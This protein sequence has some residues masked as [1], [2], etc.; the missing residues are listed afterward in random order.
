[1]DPY[2]QVGIGELQMKPYHKIQSMF[3][4]DRNNH[5][6]IIEGDWAVREFSYLADLMWTFTEKVDGTNIR[7]TWDGSK[8]SLLGR[9]ENSQTPNALMQVLDEMFPAD[10]L[11]KQFGAEEQST[12]LYG[13]GYGGGIQKGGK[14]RGDMSFVLF[15]VRCGHW[16][17]RR[18]DVDIIASE[19]GIDSVPEIDAGTLHKGIKIV[20]Q[21][22]T[23]TW[24]DFEAEGIVARPLVQ[25]F[26]RRRQRIIAKIKTCDFR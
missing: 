6:K 2:G 14:Y 13:E 16:W 10:K 17:L 1:M 18:V 3:K 4:R 26:D 24:G 7:I 22:L 20:Q 19:L 21:G 9:T 11:C 5:N 15:D 12:C 8:R 25:L 23:S